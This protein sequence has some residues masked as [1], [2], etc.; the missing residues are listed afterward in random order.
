MLFFHARARWGFHSRYTS[1]YIY[2]LQLLQ[3][4]NNPRIM[5]P[6]AKTHGNFDVQWLYNDYSDPPLFVQ[7]CAFFVLGV[8]I[9][10]IDGRYIINVLSCSREKVNHLDPWCSWLRTPRSS[11]SRTHWLSGEESVRF[12][13]G[14]FSLRV[15]VRHTFISS[16]DVYGIGRR[17]RRTCG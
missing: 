7:H 10:Y 3:R 17:G 14:L 12:T 1:I 2:S 6:F 13:P 8:S 11:A 16:L 5:P 9:E 4:P 15:Y